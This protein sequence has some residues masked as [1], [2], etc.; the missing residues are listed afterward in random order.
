M[1][2]AARGRNAR[3]ATAK[4]PPVYLELQPEITFNSSETSVLRPR[5]EY[6]PAKGDVL[7]DGEFLA[8]LPSSEP[9][10]ELLVRKDLEENYQHLFEWLEMTGWFLEGFREPLLRKA[11]Y[12][13]DMGSS[14]ETTR[15]VQGLNVPGGLPL[16]GR[17]PYDQSVAQEEAFSVPT[18]QPVDKL[19]LQDRRLRS[20]EESQGD[21]RVQRARVD[22]VG[23]RDRCSLLA[24]P[25]EHLR[26]EVPPPPQLENERGIQA[27]SHPINP[28]VNENAVLKY[29]GPVLSPEIERD[30][31]P[32]G[33]S[34]SSQQVHQ[35]GAAQVGDLDRQ[36]K[37][38]NRHRQTD[39]SYGMRDRRSRSPVFHFYRE[40]SR[41]YNGGGGRR[42]SPDRRRGYYD[43]SY[44]RR[45]YAPYDGP[46][47]NSYRPSY[48]DRSSSEYMHTYG[49][50]P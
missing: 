15:D 4:S 45:D 21:Q 38:S 39:R 42:H 13:T 19:T 43:D 40:G 5:A 41:G 8:V 10:A 36:A 31:R 3:N 49:Y 14:R 33:G 44:G 37:A 48:R 25:A 23:G 9:P 12:V 29:Q 46:Y 16:R 22:S 30:N 6:V 11:G 34:P 18:S 2:A 26:I 28:P 32:S 24:P 35:S 47:A 1:G 7:P 27:I 20:Y 50:R 17:R